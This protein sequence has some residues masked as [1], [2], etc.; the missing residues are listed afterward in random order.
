MGYSS[1][2]GDAAKH[3]YSARSSMKVDDVFKAKATHVALDPK[4]LK[5]NPNDPMGVKMRVSRD[6]DKHPESNAIAVFFDVTGS[7]GD[8]PRQFA[9]NDKG[10]LGGLMRHITTHN[11]IPHPQLFFGAIGDHRAGD[12]SPL[13]VGEFESGM[14]MDEHL[15]SLHLEGG[16]GGGHR[17]SY[18]L[19]FYFAARH[20]AMDCL[21]KR[22]K[23]GYLFLIGDESPYDSVSKN[24]VKNLLGS[25]E[26]IQGDI[27]VEEIIAECQEKFEVFFIFCDIKSYPPDTVKE[28]KARWK[29]LMGE[30]M[31]ILENPAHV[32]ELIG[33]TV[34]TNESGDLDAAYRDL[35]KTGSDKKAAD[36]AK[37]ALV[38]YLNASGTSLKKGSVSGGLPSLA[39]KGGVTEKL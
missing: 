29:E 8:V 27:K 36:A 19:A 38:P 25:D 11:Y 6:S 20:I 39:G 30:R 9:M 16:G 15:T 10:G 1:Y 31:L 7:M 12:R 26:S 21:E 14:E 17:E 2:S 32:C 5:A 4:N 3:L 23:K 28:I 34:G 13:Q 35:I 33:I 24:D 18:E 37:N 22:G